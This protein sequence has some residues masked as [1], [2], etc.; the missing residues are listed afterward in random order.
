MTNFDDSPQMVAEIVKK[1]TL[2][3]RADA[4]LY[5][6]KDSGRNNVKS[7]KDVGLKAGD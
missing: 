2:V 6:A 1:V 5:L 4:A 7:E 3:E